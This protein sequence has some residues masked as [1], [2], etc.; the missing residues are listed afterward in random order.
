MTD[1]DKRSSLPRYGINYGCKKVLWYTPLINLDFLIS[2]K[3]FLSFQKLSWFGSSILDTHTHTPSNIVKVKAY[4][5]YHL[6]VKKIAYEIG[7]Y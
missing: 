4:L 3:I 6:I 7:L 2:F 5:T 1:S